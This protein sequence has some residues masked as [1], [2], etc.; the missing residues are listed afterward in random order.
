MSL[1]IKAP[2]GGISVRKD[3]GDIVATRSVVDIHQGVGVGLSV[4]DDPIGEEVD[5]TYSTLSP[6]KD[7]LLEPEEAVLPA[8]NAP[9]VSQINGANV[10][11]KVLDFDPAAEE[12]CFWEH[13]LSP[14]YNDENIAVQI[15]WQTAAAAGD[16]VFGVSVNGRAAGEAVDGALGTVQRVVSPNGGT[17]VLNVATITTLDPLWA[18]EDVI[19]I[20]LARKAGDAADTIN[21]NDVRV[22]KVVV[23]YTQKFPQAF[24]ALNEPVNLSLGAEASWNPV[25][26]S[27][28]VPIGATGVVLHV[29]GGYGAPRIGLRKPGSTDNRIWPAV[30]NHF[31]GYAALGIERKFE[32][33][34]QGDLEVKLIGY[35]GDGV[36]FFTNGYDKT[37]GATTGWQDIDCSA[38]VPAGAIALIFEIGNP[39][40]AMDQG[41]RKKGSTDDWRLDIYAH[42]WAIIGCDTNRTVQGYRA[43]SWPEFHLVGYVTKGVTFFTNGYDKSLPA[44]GIWT[45]IDCGGETSKAIFLFIEEQSQAPGGTY[46]SMGLRKNGSAEN[47][48]GGKFGRCIH[49]FC[50]VRCDHN[51]IIEGII[52]HTDVDFRLIG[53]ATHAG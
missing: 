7:K 34:H 28:H 26:L 47:D 2:P 52:E 31:A 35:T 49:N 45:D 42:N 30:Q 3:G 33:Y 20:K 11:Y 6:H 22:I 51:A 39:N 37:P 14:D 46:Y 53:Y 48:Y 40:G 44:T 16:V 21:A 10:S 12:A 36:V 29:L 32:C 27:D 1:L 4:A 38:E 41:I 15:Y 50:C 25:D 9:A 18:K 23:S 43:H 13:W 8:I 17:N 19:F 24:Y 5:V